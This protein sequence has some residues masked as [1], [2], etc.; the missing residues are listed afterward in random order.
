MALMEAG[1]GGLPAVDLLNQTAMAMSRLVKFDPDAKDLSEL[2][3]VLSIQAEELARSLSDYQEGVEF[4][5]LRLSRWRCG[6]T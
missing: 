3:E 1:D 6:W 2:A 5:P 4:D